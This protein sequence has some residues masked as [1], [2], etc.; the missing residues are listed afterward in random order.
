MP[1]HSCQAHP[2][3][4]WPFM[5]RLFSSN[6]VSHH[7]SFYINFYNTCILQFTSTQYTLT[8]IKATKLHYTAVVIYFLRIC[9]KKF[10]TKI[11]NSHRIL[12]EIWR[13]FH[14]KK[15]TLV[16]KSHEHQRSEGDCLKYLVQ[17]AFV[18]KQ[19]L[20][21]ATKIEI[22]CGNGW[23]SLL[24]NIRGREWSGSNNPHNFQAHFLNCYLQILMRNEQFLLYG[25]RSLHWPKTFLQWENYRH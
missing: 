10:Q 14:I 21:Y 12:D 11:Q 25:C 15:L 1:H 19:C 13:E 9:K 22:N 2:S 8:L 18:S 24:W 17:V 16:F 7:T 20:K 6:A 3:D 4:M 23:S 5:S